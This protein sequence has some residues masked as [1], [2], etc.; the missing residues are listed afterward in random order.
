MIRFL[1]SL[2]VKKNES[3]MV[4][5]LSFLR[6]INLC[7]LFKAKFC[8]YIYI[9][10]F[11]LRFLDEYFVGKIF[12]KQDFVYLHTI[13][14]FQL[15]MFLVQPC[16]SQERQ[17]IIHFD[18]VE[19]IFQTV[20]LENSLSDESESSTFYENVINGARFLTCQTLRL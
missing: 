8:L 11:N 3:F 7:R 10:T 5:W 12:D 13:E 15:I 4:G 6:H 9:Y 19:Q 20:Y 14:W 17:N 18:V 16:L 1:I 2:Q